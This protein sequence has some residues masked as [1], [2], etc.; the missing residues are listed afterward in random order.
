MA[1]ASRFTTEK[2]LCHYSDLD[3]QQTQNL[4]EP[5]SEYPRASPNY[6]PHR[7][8][9]RVRLDQLWPTGFTLGFRQYPIWRLGGR[10]TIAHSQTGKNLCSTCDLGTLDKRRTE[11]DRRKEKT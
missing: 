10:Q 6:S 9:R 5:Y 7:V 4:S 8:S 11:H 2:L 1:R 3:V